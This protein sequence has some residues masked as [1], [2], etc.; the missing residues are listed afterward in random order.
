MKI[1][2]IFFENLGDYTVSIRAVLLHRDQRG[3]RTLK[4]KKSLWIRPQKK[5]QEIK[6]ALYITKQFLLSKETIRTMS[7][8]TEW[9]KWF[10]DKG[11]VNMQIIL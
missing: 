9:C 8:S 10:I 3:Y 2:I 4:Q 1:I 7:Q 6:A 5:S 11:L